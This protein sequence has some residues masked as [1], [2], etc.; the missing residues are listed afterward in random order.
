MFDEARRAYV[1][2]RLDG[3]DTLLM[4]YTREDCRELSRQI[5]E[6]LVHLGLVEGGP[7]VRLTHGASAS[8]GEV[9]V[10]RENDNQ[11]ITGEDHTLANGDIF[12]GAAIVAGGVV[13]G[14]VAEAAGAGSRRGAAS[15]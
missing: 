1:A 9:V 12:R 13:G 6:D 15:R 11:M 4:A 10:C 2:D 8:A 5:R 7:E 3:Q 14:R